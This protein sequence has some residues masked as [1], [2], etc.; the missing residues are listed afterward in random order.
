MIYVSSKAGKDFTDFIQTETKGMNLTFDQKLQIRQATL[1]I[2]YT[3]ILMFFALVQILVSMI[4]FFES[5]TETE[6][7]KTKEETINL[8]KLSKQP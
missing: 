4:T 6:R 5:V 3:V 2:Y 8:F 1:S 7:K